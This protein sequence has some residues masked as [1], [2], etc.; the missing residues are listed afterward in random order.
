MN[1]KVECVGC[2]RTHDPEKSPT[3]WLS[4]DGTQP[5]VPL[6]SDC[7]TV[8][9]EREAV[10]EPMTKASE[11]PCGHNVYASAHE[12]FSECHICMKK[13][14]EAWKEFDR[15]YSK[16]ALTR[17]AAELF[18]VAHEAGERS[19]TNEDRDFFI[20]GTGPISK[21]LHRFINE[22]GEHAKI[23]NELYEHGFNVNQMVDQCGETAKGHGFWDAHREK[24]MQAVN[25]SGSRQDDY[26]LVKETVDKLVKAR[27][28]GDPTI[29]MALMM[30]EMAE[31]IEGYRKGNTVGKDGMWEELADVVVRLFDFI[32]RYGPDDEI[33]GEIFMALVAAKMAKNESRPHLHNKAF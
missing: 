26:P 18:L 31:A 9:L 27:L 19:M 30:T 13:E 15:E 16:N 22:A 24:A 4:R 11:L 1:A 28:L 2:R 23:F 8:A 29:F 3:F 20:E 7:W 14:L 17:K 6:C 32:A 33:S 25:V 21:L 10:E 12:A 5:E